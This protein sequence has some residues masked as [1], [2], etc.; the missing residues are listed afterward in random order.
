MLDNTSNRK[1]KQ[2]RT[3]KVG[4]N[5]IWW[6]PLDNYQK[7]ILAALV[8]FENRKTGR[9]DPSIVPCLTTQSGVGKSKV[10]DVLNELESM[11]IITRKERYNTHGR[12]SN[13]Y[14]IH[15]ERIGQ[16][17]D[18]DKYK[19]TERVRPTDSLSPPHG[20]TTVRHADSNLDMD[21]SDIELEPEFSE[22]ESI[23]RPRKIERDKI[24]REDQELQEIEDYQKH[25]PK[26]QSI[27]PDPTAGKRGYDVD[28]RTLM[29]MSSS[30]N[31]FRRAYERYGQDLTD[32][33]TYL[34]KNFDKG[35]AASIGRACRENGTY[36]IDD[37][38]SL[39][40]VARGAWLTVLANSSLFYQWA[41]TLSRGIN[42][43]GTLDTNI[44][45]SRFLQHGMSPHGGDSDSLGEITMGQ[46]F[47]DNYADIVS[48]L[49]E[50]EFSQPFV[51]PDIADPYEDD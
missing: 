2:P 50:Q 7:T 44:K 43:V 3:P 51:L 21:N 5:S 27:A 34:P 11:D 41:G 16:L 31:F 39:P 20:L 24:V 17:T 49:E 35:A 32:P 10:S 18:R 36:Y 8:S 23:S 6:T 26:L 48:D 37:D 19:G 22:S 38:T 30:I 12:S 14:D 15:W 4:S 1:S 9:C 47:H 25:R 45:V 29:V 42:N 40:G 28:D 13:Q 46:Y 33:S